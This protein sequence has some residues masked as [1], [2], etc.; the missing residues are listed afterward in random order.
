MN[1]KKVRESS[2][3][4][5]TFEINASNNSQ[6]S[7]LAKTNSGVHVGLCAQNWRPSNE[8]VLRAPAVLWEAGPKASAT[9]LS[10]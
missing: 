6:G 5:S 2:L 4:N 3:L 7:L 8:A 10:L 9:P 1:K